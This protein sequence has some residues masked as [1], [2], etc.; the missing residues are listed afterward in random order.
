MKATTETVTPT[1]KRRTTN[2]RDVRRRMR[3]WCGVERLLRQGLEFVIECWCHAA[4]DF[5]PDNRSSRCPRRLTGD[6]GR[7][8]VTP[9]L[10]PASSKDLAVL[11]G[12]G[13][14]AS[15]VPWLHRCGRARL[16]QFG[17]AS[18]CPLVCWRWV[19]IDRQSGRVDRRRSVEYANYVRCSRRVDDRGPISVH[20]KPTI[21]G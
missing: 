16:E 12:L 9:A 8:P 21:L 13:A 2:R 7:E 18:R 19:G 11:F 20:E 3:L 14:D 15:G 6:L 5:L 4:H 1:I 17:M 10:A